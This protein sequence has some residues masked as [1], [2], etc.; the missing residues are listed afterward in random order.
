MHSCFYPK[1]CV[2]NKHQSSFISLW[3]FFPSELQCFSMLSQCWVNACS[4]V[5]ILLVL[6]LMLSTVAAYVNIPA[7]L[8]H[9]TFKVYLTYSVKRLTE[10]DGRIR[11]F[12]FSYFSQ[13]WFSKVDNWKILVLLSWILP[14][15]CGGIRPK[16]IL[17]LIVNDWVP[18]ALYLMLH[19]IICKQY[20]FV[21]V[22]HATRF[23]NTCFRPLKFGLSLL[24]PLCPGLGQSKKK[25]P[26]TSPSSSRRI[27]RCFQGSRDT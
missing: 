17:K 15:N 9:C 19:P 1:V 23:K 10:Y 25:C 26:T 16:N 6:G 7:G 12:S 20:V 21:F 14:H 2:S 18:P 4:I 24:R 11:S 22:C 8:D 3:Q 5:D 13:K 27:P